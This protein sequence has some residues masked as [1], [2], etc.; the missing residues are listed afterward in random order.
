MD[1]LIQQIKQ[2]NEIYH[3]MKRNFDLLKK[4]FN[5]DS[6]IKQKTIL[7]EQMLGQVYMSIM[8]KIESRTINEEFLKIIKG[9]KNEKKSS[10]N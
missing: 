9:I 8:A 3:S 2:L 1:K 6:G 4:M 7:T 10:Q 5:E